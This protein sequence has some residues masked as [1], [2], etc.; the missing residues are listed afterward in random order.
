MEAAGALLLAYQRGRTSALEPIQAMALFSHD[1][2]D[3][4]ELPRAA[5]LH[6]GVGRRWEL[7]AEGLLDLAGRLPGESE[8]AGWRLVATDGDSLQ[9][10]RGLAPDVQ[11][12]AGP[13]DTVLELGLWLE[14]E[15][16]AIEAG[17]IRRG[18]ERSPLAGSR[19]LARW[20]EA[21]RL[22]SALRHGHSTL[23]LEIDRPADAWGVDAG[24]A[25]RR[26]RLRID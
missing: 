19:Q 21:E 12:L 17:R 22:L 11:R 26:L 1:P 20:M 16:A 10:A 8:H 23:D 3:V 7:P 5:V 13:S 25:E 15:R 24:A 14:L 2:T 9:R 6:D 18:F 4:A